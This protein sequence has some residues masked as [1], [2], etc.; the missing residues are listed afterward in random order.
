MVADLVHESPLGKSDHHCV[1]NLKYKCYYELSEG[2]VQRWNF[3][4]GDY[5]KMRENMSFKCDT[6]L[7][8][9]DLSSPNELLGAFMDKFNEAKEK[10][11]P[12]INSKANK[13]AKKHN[14][15]PLDEKTISEIK[16]KH[17]C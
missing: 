4:K 15:L 13:K 3:H 16:K 10:C 8:E 6:V 7:L 2:K 14:Y 1:L 9:K 11:I 12:R 17:R 5:A